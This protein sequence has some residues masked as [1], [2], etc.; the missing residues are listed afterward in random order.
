MPY[1]NDQRVAAYRSYH[2]YST[3]FTVLTVVGALSLVGVVMSLCL[4][5]PWYEGTLTGA[6]A[7][8]LLLRPPVQ[9]GNS[10]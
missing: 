7:V 10:Q 9:M 8:Y 4:G 1:D 5:R 2:R 6:L 3:F